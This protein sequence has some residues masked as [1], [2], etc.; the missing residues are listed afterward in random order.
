M[1]RLHNEQLTIWDFA[2]P[3]QVLELSKELKTIDELLDDEKFMRPFLSRW[4]IRIGRPTVPVE[5]FLR[6][7]YLKFRY[8]FGYETLV[9]EVSDSIKWRRFCRINLDATVP[10][11]TTL[12]KLTQKYGEDIVEQLNEALV[13]KASQDKI[14]RSRR[15]RTDTTVTESNIHYPTDAQL[16]ADAIKSITRQAQSLRETAGSTMP[17]M[18]ERCRSAKKRILEIGKTLK[19]R[20]H[21]A[22]EEVRKIT[23]KLVDKAIETMTNAHQIMDKAEEALGEQMSNTTKRKIEKL[24]KVIVTADKIVNQTL[25]VNGGNTHISNRVI[26]LHDPD[27]RPIQ[28][29]KLKSPTEFGYKTEITENEDR[30]ITDYKVHVGNPSDDSLLVETVK[31]H[32]SKTGKVPYSIAT[33]RGY[34]SGKNQKELTDLGIKRISMPKKGKKSKAQASH[35][36]QRWFR[37]LQAWRAGGEGTISILKRKYGLGRSLSRGHQGVS[38]WVGFGILTYNLRRIA[39]L[40]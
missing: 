2:L 14:T 38:T 40:I 8:E 10:H 22:V 23:D 15:L 36:K 17:K 34:S 26:S 29:G 31:R 28:K 25:K 18:I 5:T 9:A 27:A 21:Q 19:R 37:R 32:I 1:L 6:L 35:E 11:S 4:N 24:D 39:A 33:D 20:N 3:E 13:V 12:I 7:M 16:L 30:I